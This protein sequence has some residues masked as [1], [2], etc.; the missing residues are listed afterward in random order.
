MKQLTFPGEEL[1]ARREELGLSIQDVFER[2]RIPLE[3]LV[4]LERGRLRSLPN[5]CYAVGFLKTY[6][7]FLELDSQRFV[8]SYRAAARPTGGFFRR[9]Q[10]E[11]SKAPSLWMVD[12][13]TWAAI[14]GVL[15]FVWFA[16]SAVIRPQ[17]EP[18]EHRVDAQ[19]IDF[20]KHP[21]KPAP[22]NY[23]Y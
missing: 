21:A 1:H 9:K 22:N 2:T 19:T 13:M 7:H 15:L 16:Y 11:I 4:A 3:Y 14:C 5:A 23:D 17:A 12:L 18:A 10:V 20:A 8:N 6:C